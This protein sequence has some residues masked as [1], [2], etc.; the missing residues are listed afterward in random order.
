MARTITT[1]QGACLEECLHNNTRPT[2]R[3]ATK[4]TSTGT[5][6]MSLTG[7]MDGFKFERAAHSVRDFFE[8]TTP[9]DDYYKNKTTTAYL[10]NWK[11]ERLVYF[12]SCRNFHVWN[13]AWFKRPDLP[14]GYDGWQVIDCCPQDHMISSSEYLPQKNYIISV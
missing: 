3:T 10:K 13:E 7:R 1:K 9:I 6:T 4:T 2:A 11:T 14:D 12:L 8:P 5:T